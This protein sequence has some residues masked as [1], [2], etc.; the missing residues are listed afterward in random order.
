MSTPT[1]DN[2]DFFNKNVILRV[3]WNVPTKDVIQDD[4]ITKKSMITDDTRIRASLPT[5]RKILSDGCKRIVII[6]HFGRPNVSNTSKLGLQ[7]L[8]KGVTEKYSWFNYIL[9]I[10]KTQRKFPKYS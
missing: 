5:I 1:I 9:S 10:L 3:D 2:I 6:S 4:G 8:P 7:E